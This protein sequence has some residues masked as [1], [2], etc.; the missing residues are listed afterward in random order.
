MRRDGNFEVKAVWHKSTGEVGEGVSKNF[1]HFSAILKN[2]QAETSPSLA[3]RVV[4]RCGFVDMRWLPSDVFHKRQF[5]SKPRELDT[6]SVVA[7]E[8]LAAFR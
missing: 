3:C 5:R 4:D 2:T 8:K 7:V 1:L 6:S